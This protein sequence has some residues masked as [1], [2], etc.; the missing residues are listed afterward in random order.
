MDIFIKNKSYLLQLFKNIYIT[1]PRIL[2]S[3]FAEYYDEHKIS[4]NLR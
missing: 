3:K 4:H 2:H 1:L